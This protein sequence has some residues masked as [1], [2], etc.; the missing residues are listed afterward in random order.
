MTLGHASYRYNGL[1]WYP[2][3]EG[4]VANVPFPDGASSGCKV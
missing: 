3:F 1:Q 4:F 2:G